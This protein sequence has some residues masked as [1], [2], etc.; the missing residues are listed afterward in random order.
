[1]L[2]G[3]RRTWEIGAQFA[4]SAKLISSLESSNRSESEIANANH[5]KKE[6]RTRTAK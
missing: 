3:M 4:D 2:A 5:K 1:M 6:E